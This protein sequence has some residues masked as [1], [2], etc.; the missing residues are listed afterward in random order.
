MVLRRDH[1]TE[2]RAAVASLLGS[3]TGEVLVGIAGGPMV[4]EVGFV[5]VI[6]VAV[7][8]AS[9]HRAHAGIVEILAGRHIEYSIV[10]APL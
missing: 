6:T 5:L 10:V 8:W 7:P 9:L 2:V 4:E 3:I 1:P